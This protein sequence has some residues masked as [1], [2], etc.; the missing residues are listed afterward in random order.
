MLQKNGGG[1]GNR[2]IEPVISLTSC[3]LG[4]LTE[5]QPPKN[6]TMV[7]EMVAVGSSFA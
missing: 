7:A 4:I 2:V 5:R 3:I 1:G 6:E